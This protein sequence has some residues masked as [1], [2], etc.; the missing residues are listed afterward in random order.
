MMKHRT[1]EVTALAVLL[2]LMTDI[3]AACDV[4][5]GSPSLAAGSSASAPA[6]ADAGS[7]APAKVA[8]IPISAPTQ[9]SAPAASVAIALSPATVQVKRGETFSIEVQLVAGAQ[10]LD[11]VQ[12]SLSF[13]PK[14]AQV[15]D[16]T[17]A[18]ATAV[19]AG[20]ALPTLLLNQADNAKGSIDYAAGAAFEP[21]KEP[22]GTFTLATMHLKALQAGQT[23]ISF[24]SAPPHKTEAA[25]GGKFVPVKEPAAGSITI[26]P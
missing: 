4:D 6:R 13:D 25:Y 15:V 12:A 14:Y 23:T 1:L 17:G 8:N 21:G 19:E 18:P 3:A 10:K 24:A 7:P 5:Q 2:L 26:S 20:K 16:T 11:A 22:S 9:A